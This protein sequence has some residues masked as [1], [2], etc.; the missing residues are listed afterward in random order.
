MAPTTRPNLGRPPTSSSE[1]TLKALSPVPET[2]SN[3]FDDFPSENDSSGAA[4]GKPPTA[5]CKQAAGKHSSWLPDNDATLRQN[6]H[7]TSNVQKRVPASEPADGLST[8]PSGPPAFPPFSRPVRATRNP[9]PCYVDSIQAVKAWS[10][11]P[12]ELIALN[13]SI[14]RPRAG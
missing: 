1:A 9:N 2:P 3:L 6:N 14:N 13:N 5:I 4:T 11:S 12:N 7:A 10:A 8:A